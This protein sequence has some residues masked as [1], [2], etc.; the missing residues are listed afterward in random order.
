MGKKPTIQL[1]D[2]Y[3][4]KNLTDEEYQILRQKGTEPPFSGK[5]LYCDEE[6]FY[7]CRA[8]GQKLFLSRYKFHSDS[9]WPSFSKAVRGAVEIRLDFS[10]F[11]IRSEVIC[12]CCGSHLGHLFYDYGGKTGLRYCINSLAMQFIKR[13]A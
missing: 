9:G 2:D 6:G 3:F 11:M 12:S 5:Y 8:C 1:T 13:K 10:H 7:Y 4:R